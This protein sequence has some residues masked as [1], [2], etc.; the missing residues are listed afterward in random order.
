MH[1]SM[2]L[3]S[4]DQNRLRIGQRHQMGSDRELGVGA[5]GLDQDMAMRMR[6]PH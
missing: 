1:I 6:V 3:P 4:V 2:R 5:V